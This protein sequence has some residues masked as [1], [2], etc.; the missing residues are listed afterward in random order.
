MTLGQFVLRIVHFHRKPVPGHHSIEGLFEN[1]RDELRSRELN[2]DKKELPYF[3]R[4]IVPRVLSTLWARNNQGDINHITGDVHFLALGLDP[5]RTLLTIHDLEILNYVRGIRR[6]LLKLFWYDLPLRF[7]GLVTV[8][9]EATKQ[10][11]ITQ[12]NISNDKIIVVP[13]CV[14]RTYRPSPRTF[15]AENP[16]ILQIGT[17]P[18]KN[19]ERLMAAIDGLRCH[20][21]VVGRLTSA[22]RNELDRRGIAHTINVN[23]TESEMY[24]AYCTADIVSLV[25]TAEGF[26][27]PIIEAQWI[28]RPVVTSNCSSMPEVAGKGACLVDPFDVASIRSGIVQIIDDE[29]YRNG[30]IVAGQENRI[31]FSIESVA[32]GYSNAYERLASAT[33]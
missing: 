21:H 23:L 16:R 24:Q 6:W 22:Q 27:M 15:N 8:I 12:C 33:H 13:D 32:S 14:S 25:S 19:L 31:R 11:L 28:E 7:A 30:L 4:G 10:A 29:A 18:H 1:L 3:S 17:K 5:R 26:G 2:V 20:L 9:S